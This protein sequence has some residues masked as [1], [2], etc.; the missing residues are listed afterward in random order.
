MV[1]SGDPA[2]AS[3]DWGVDSKR[4]PFSQP[5]RCPRFMTHLPLAQ[6]YPLNPQARR[7]TFI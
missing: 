5:R 1:N 6:R 2:T 4:Q 3:I 7:G